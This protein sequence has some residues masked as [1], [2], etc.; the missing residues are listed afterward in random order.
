MGK[1]FS[2]LMIAL[3]TLAA[4]GALAF[5][6]DSTGGGIWRDPDVPI[7]NPDRR[8]PD[9]PIPLSNPLPFP[10]S[11][12][13][14]VW[15]AK[16]AGVNALFSFEV[17][18][19]GEGRQ[20][21]KVVHVNTD[22]TEIVARGT[23]FAMQASNEVRAGMISYWGSYMLYIGLYEDEKALGGPKKMTVLRIMPFAQPQEQAI[24]LVIRKVSEKPVKLPTTV[25]DRSIP[26]DEHR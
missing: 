14:G 20:I 19:Q 3:C 25:K 10:W 2:T 22:L 17:V 18:D 4:A 1:L 16:S 24:T 12:I 23:G 21:L 26:A 6:G 5:S 7:P 13:E 11:T 9:V 15:E 8:D